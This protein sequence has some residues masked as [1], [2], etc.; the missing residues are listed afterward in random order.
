MKRVRKVLD[1][2]VF[3]EADSTGGYVVSCP[4]LPGC[5]SQGDTVEEAV[6]NIKKAIELCLEDMIERKERLPDTARTFVS[7]VVVTV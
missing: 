4:S 3:L 7:S 1:F 6:E 2:K 5:F